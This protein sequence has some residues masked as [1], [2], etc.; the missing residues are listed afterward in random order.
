[1]K[2]SHSF[3]FILYLIVSFSGSLEAEDFVASLPEIPVLSEP[4]GNGIFVQL[5]EALD[6]EYTEGKISYDIVPFQRSLH[7]V[8]RGK[9]DFHLPL[10]EYESQK[11]DGLKLSEFSLYTVQFS[12]FSNRSKRIVTRKDIDSLKA[13]DQFGLIIE[14]DRTHLSQFDFPVLA[15][16]CME[17]SLKKLTAGR[18]DALIFGGKSIS[19]LREKLL[20]DNIHEESFDTYEVKFVVGDTPRGEVVE[21]KLTA[22]FNQL[23]ESGEYERMLKSLIH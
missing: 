16:S 9:A 15:S 22:V 19:F 17:C 5:I 4:S 7:N 23:K 10:I 12:I 3:Q 11:L 8:A 20:L 6:E 2:N 21:R 1:M 13:T 18:I 14:T